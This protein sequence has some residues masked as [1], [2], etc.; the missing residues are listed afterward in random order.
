MIAEKEDVLCG[1]KESDK[2][3]RPNSLP[4]TVEQLMER[5]RKNCH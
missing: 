4:R 5:R 2:A 1:I 3:G